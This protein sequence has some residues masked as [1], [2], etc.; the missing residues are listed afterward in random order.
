MMMHTLHKL[1]EIREA[2]F[3]GQENWFDYFPSNIRPSDAIILAGSGATS[4]LHR[5]PFEW[6]GMS[7]CLEGIKIWRFILPPSLEDGGVSIVDGAL[8]SYQLD[9]IAWEQDGGN[10]EREP[11]AWSAGWQ[12]DM[13]LFDF[14]SIWLQMVDQT[15]LGCRRELE[16]AGLDMSTL[17]PC[18]GA[19]NAFDVVAKSTGSLLQPLFSTAIQQQGDFAAYSCS[20]LASNVAPVPSVAVASQ[21]CSSRFY[22]R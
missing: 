19:R 6:T 4:T 11:V 15:G 5:D 8:S 20:L 21:R 3:V 13:S 7:I 16:L 17:Q 9:S 10:E 12:S 1:R 2:P 14:D 22:D 18:N